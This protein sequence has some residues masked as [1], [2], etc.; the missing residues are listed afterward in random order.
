MDKHATARI[1]RGARRGGG[2]AAS[3]PP[4]I[5]ARHLFEAFIAAGICSMLVRTNPEEKRRWK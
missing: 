1:R 2:M 4:M 5:K 3:E